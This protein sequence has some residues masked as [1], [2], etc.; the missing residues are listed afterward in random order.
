M[1]E[2]PFYKLVV[3]AVF[4]PLMFLIHFVAAHVMTP[5]GAEAL[6]ATQILLAMG[7]AFVIVEL[8]R[9]LILGESFGSFSSVEPGKKVLLAVMLIGAFALSIW[10][11]MFLHRSDH[12]PRD[13]EAERL[14]EQIRA[15]EHSDIKMP[16]PANQP[17][18]T[19]SPFDPHAMEKLREERL[20]RLQQHASQGQYRSAVSPTTHPN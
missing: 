2:N 11:G 10:V 20:L 8:G 13:I 12:P 1:L 16:Q 4:V 17:T 19:V 15:I 14:R 9:K 7:L 6:I 5:E 18:P 3:L